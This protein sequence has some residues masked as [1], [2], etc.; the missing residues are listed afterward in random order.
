MHNHIQHFPQAFPQDP[1]CEL[2]VKIS[3]IPQFYANFK[4]SMQLFI[5]INKHLS[6]HRIF[7]R[8]YTKM[9]KIINLPHFT[10]KVSPR[11]DLVA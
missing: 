2:P 11:M 7:I 10:Y 4:L 1:L 6:S 8:N 5:I 9:R 3:R